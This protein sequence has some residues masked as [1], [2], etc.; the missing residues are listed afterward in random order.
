[1]LQAFFEPAMAPF[2]IAITLMLIIAAVELLGAMMG[3]PASAAFDSLLPEIDMDGDAP[4]LLDAPTAGPLSHVLG[5]LCVGR[6]PVLV[7]LI[8][9][10]TAF[11]LAGFALQSVV[12][13]L[14]GV[15]APAVLAAIPAF[16]AALPVVRISGMTIALIMP[17]EETDAVSQAR[18]IGKVATIIRGEARQ[19]QPAEAKFKDRHGHTHY[20]LVEPDEADA[21]FAQG[22]NVVIV[23]QVGS[24]Y[25]AIRSDSAAFLDRARS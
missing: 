10:L 13:S 4:S 5:W 8:V 25:T 14:L 23:K 12:H 6:V 7:L 16:F 15:F 1:M 18:F 22:E 9:F 21:T 20:A 2:A 24:I 17:K 19:G 3:V 11:G